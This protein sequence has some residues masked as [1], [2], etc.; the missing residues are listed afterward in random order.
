LELD[1]PKDLGDLEYPTLKLGKGERSPRLIQVPRA[2]AERSRSVSRFSRSGC[3][4][5]PNF[6][7]LGSRVPQRSLAFGAGDW[8]GIK[9]DQHP[10][11]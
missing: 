5:S 9:R 3:P 7:D 1:T 2:C 11:P 8:S 6:G 4:R 10:P